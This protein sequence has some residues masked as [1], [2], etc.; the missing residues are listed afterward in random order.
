M[1]SDLLQLSCGVAACQVTLG[2]QLSVSG[3]CLP[4]TY[5]VEPCCG[6]GLRWPPATSA[7]DR[8]WPSFRARNADRG[9]GLGPVRDPLAHR[10]GRS[11][12]RL[13]QPAVEEGRNRGEPCRPVGGRVR[14]AGARAFSRRGGGL[15][16][17][18]HRSSRG[19][20]RRAR[21]RLP[22]ARGGPAPRGQALPARS[23]PQ[24]RLAVTALLG[25][26][27]RP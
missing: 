13:H 9:G 10:R 11:R 24:R 3:P 12:E 5:L 14:R 20:G 4:G 16:R 19:N 6:T 17:R 25:G 2:Q 27:G 7:R 23:A 18:G 21:T 15:P 1:R 8:A 22:H 26:P